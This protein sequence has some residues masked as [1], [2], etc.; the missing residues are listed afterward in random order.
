MPT[1]TQTSESFVAREY[2]IKVGD[3]ECIVRAAAVWPIADVLELESQFEPGA[4]V[5]DR[6]H[7][8]ALVADVLDSRMIAPPRPR[9]RRERAVS[10]RA[11][12]YAAVDD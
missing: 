7:D 3:S 6:D 12:F 1:T 9:R 2:S 11:V 8:A 5:A 4:D 10:S